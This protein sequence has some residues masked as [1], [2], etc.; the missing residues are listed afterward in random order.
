MP[1]TRGCAKFLK[2]I[3]PPIVYAVIVILSSF[4]GQLICE[5]SLS[6]AVV[7]WETEELEACMSS[8]LNKSNFCFRRFCVIAFEIPSYTFCIGIWQGGVDL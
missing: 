6:V 2:E 4:K 5:R 3:S 8:F 7:S 1:I